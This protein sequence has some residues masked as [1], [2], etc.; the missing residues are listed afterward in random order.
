MSKQTGNIPLK[1]PDLSDTMEAGHLVRWLKKPG[2]KINKG[3]ILAEIESDKSLMEMEAFDEGYLAGPLAEEDTDIAVGAIMAYLSQSPEVNE[4]SNTVPVVGTNMSET[5][6]VDIT[7]PEHKLEPQPEH[8]PEPQLKLQPE[9]FNTRSETLVKHKTAPSIT[10]HSHI[11]ASP[12]A[13]GL[14]QELGIDLAYVQADAGGVI[15]SPQVIAAAMNGPQA[16]LNSGPAWRYKLFTPMHRAIANNMIASSN[17]PT[18]RISMLLATDDLIR[19]AHNKQL[20]I[21]LILARALALS[22][23]KHPDFNAVYT[24]HGLAVRKQ[25]DVGIA[26]DI[27]GGLVTPVLRDM[28]RRPMQELADNWQQLKHKIK[29]TGLQP[30]EYQGAT[31]YLSNLG[32]FEGISRFDAIV[33]AGACAI[34]AIAASQNGLAELTLSVDHRVV[35]GAEAARFMQTLKT[36]LHDADNL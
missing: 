24:P 22:V 11:K 34:L 13:R 33:P 3:D 12:Y 1:M 27:P 18:F 8:Q 30:Q 10:H 31:V 14:A 23:E 6:T 29:S 32:M 28:S 2:D 19:T 26:V 9:V 7:K 21:T 15:K 4:N 17:T 20:S 25:I 36:L 35:Y 16:N 5:K